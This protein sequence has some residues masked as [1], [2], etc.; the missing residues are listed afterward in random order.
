[1]KKLMIDAS[2]IS[3]LNA[4]HQFFRTQL[5]FPDYYGNNLDALYDMLSTWDEP[6]QI[7][8][9]AAADGHLTR[10]IRLLRDVSRDNSKIHLEVL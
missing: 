2:Q 3:D 1:M 6:L 5:D 7:T 9:T 8:V 4:V 10:L